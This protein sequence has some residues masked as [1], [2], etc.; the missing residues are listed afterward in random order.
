[1]MYIILFSVTL[2]EAEMSPQ[3]LFQ[4]H[5]ALGYVAWLLCFGVYILPWLKSMDPF[6]AQRVIATL[7]SF[8]F[9]GLVFMLPGV[10]GPNL[11]TRFAEFAAYWDLATGVLAMLA[12]LTA[13]IRPLFWL[14]VVAFNLVG[15]VDLVLDYYHAVRVGLPALS[16]QLGATYAI[17]IIYVPVLMIT[18]CTA[19]YLLLRPRPNVARGLAGPV[20]AS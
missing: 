1:M 19:F 7:H 20:V 16:G 3:T 18:H 8:R 5:L 14:F 2:K 11:P 15:A 10:V 6:E 12:L 9:F 17:P 13:R 4:I